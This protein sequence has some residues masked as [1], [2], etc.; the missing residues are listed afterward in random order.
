MI[1]DRDGVAYLGREQLWR[2]DGEDLKAV[3]P[4]GFRFLRA[5]AMDG[6]G[7][8]WMGGVNKFGVYDP[9]SDTYES[10]LD[11]IPEGQ[12]NLGPIWELHH[13]GDH[14]WLGTGN[15]LFRLSAEEAVSWKF[16]GKHRVIFHFLETGVFAHETGVGLWKIEGN[17]RVL[18][19]DDP[20][21]REKSILGLDRYD[22]NS[23]VGVSV[24][25]I[26]KLSSNLENVLS[27]HKLPF[28]DTVISASRI[29]NSNIIAFGT[30][31]KGVYLLSKKGEI[32]AKLPIKYSVNSELVLDLK[33]DSKGNLWVLGNTGVWSVF[34]D[35]PVSIIDKSMGFEAG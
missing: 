32:R 35:I 2:W 26:F 18:V 29:I 13:A 11:W 30:L 33:L 14:L 1:W 31:G 15:T 22:T 19:N 3:G 4:D 9:E 34:M 23:F 6:R 25:G 17:E 12:R 20:R 21:L 16:S 5:L 27:I 28:I 10:R 7:R 24:N 8:I